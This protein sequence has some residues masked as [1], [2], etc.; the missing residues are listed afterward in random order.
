VSGQGKPN[1]LQHAWILWGLTALMVIFGVAAEGLNGWMAAVVGVFGFIL[2]LI[3]LR[4]HRQGR[5]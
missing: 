5:K 3:R 1:A 4:D 2:G